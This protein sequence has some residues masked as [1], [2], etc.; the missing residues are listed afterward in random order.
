VTFKC[1]RCGDVFNSLN[2]AAQH[3]QKS[4]ADDHGDVSEYAAAEKEV[5]DAHYGAPNGDNSV[6]DPDPQAEARN[7]LEDIREAREDS[8]VTN[9]ADT[10]STDPPEPPEPDIDDHPTCPECGGPGEPVKK[11]VRRWPD[12]LQTP[13]VDAFTPFCPDCPTADSNGDQTEVWTG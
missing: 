4:N 11:L 12:Q 2:N 9:T 6:V 8:G 7:E 13:P 10:G 1:P 3:L 5:A